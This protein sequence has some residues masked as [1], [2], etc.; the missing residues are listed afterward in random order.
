MGKRGDRSCPLPHIPRLLCHDGGIKPPREGE[1]SMWAAEDPR[2]DRGLRVAGP[3]LRRRP[4]ARVCWQDFLATW[5]TFP[6]TRNGALQSRRAQAKT[7]PQ[8]RKLTKLLVPLSA[9]KLDQL[10]GLLSE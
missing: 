9:S 7:A 6:P 1:Q 8:D 4:V 10:R 5:P 3:G 2:S